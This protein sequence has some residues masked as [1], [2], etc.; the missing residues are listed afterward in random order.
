VAVTAGLMLLVYTLTRAPRV[1]W[2]SAE[3]VASFVGFVVLIGAAVLIEQRSRSPL[4]DL[5]IFRRRTLTGANLIGLVLGTVVFGAFFLLTL[6]QQDVLGF[7]PLRTGV[8]NLAI[9]KR[10]SRRP[11][12]RGARSPRAAPSALDHLANR[13]QRVVAR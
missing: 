4:V 6:Y 12:R 8:N 9:A 3:T 11:G 10:L 7:S 13:A 1:G 2:G 5:R